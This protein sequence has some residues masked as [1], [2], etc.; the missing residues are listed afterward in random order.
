VHTKNRSK[1]KKK[2][3]ATVKKTAATG[4]IPRVLEYSIIKYGV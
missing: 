4:N 1:K 2:T 3:A